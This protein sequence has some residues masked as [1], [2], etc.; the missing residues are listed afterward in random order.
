MRFS[1]IAAAAICVL[2]ILDPV[3][4]ASAA[5]T[6]QVSGP[7]AYENLAVYFI[8]G[9]SAT[10]PVPLTLDEALS[11]G[12]V[13]VVETGEVNEL[14]IENTGGEPV[15]I[16]SGDIVKG[17][18]QDRT[19]T[20]SLILP[21]HSGEISIASF[22]VEHGRWSQRG[23]EDAATFASAAE[24]IPS[25][26]VKLAMK[27]PLAAHETQPAGYDVDGTPTG[28]EGEVYERQKQVWDSVAKTQS[29]LSGSLSTNVASEQSETSLQLALENDKLKERR[30]AYVS[31]L[32]DAGKGSD[33][34]VG[35]A[36]AVNGKLNSADV[37]SSNGL[38]RKMWP[39]Q[40]QAAATEAIGDEHV[41]N[42]TPPT[43]AAVTEFLDSA[44]RGSA[45]ETV[46]SDKTRIE[47]RATPDA[48]Y[49]ATAPASGGFIHENYLAR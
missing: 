3:R 10:G 20:T 46:L 14:N 22:C 49:S 7:V 37:Y 12:S 42:T 21:P 24:A 11:K 34:I 33:D 17:G 45:S 19:L 38:F 28:S 30:A 23:S 40:L 41:E 47:T 25:R 8:H 31:A 26:E 5:E 6:Q 13:K 2:G 35:Y 36:F 32:Q 43:I 29:K 4:G 48:V 27:A 1:S 9:A 39:K 18:R 15:F 44:K 16:Q